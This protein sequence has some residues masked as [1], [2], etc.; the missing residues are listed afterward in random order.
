MESPI[1]VS[2]TIKKQLADDEKKKKNQFMDDIIELSIKHGFFQS[3]VL[4][5]TNNGILPDIELVTLN[6]K[7]KNELRNRKQPASNK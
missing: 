1:Q 4:R 3:P 5:Y 2:P 7:Q 6:E